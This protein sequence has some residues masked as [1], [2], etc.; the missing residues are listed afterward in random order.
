MSITCEI[1][2]Q[3]GATPEQ[4]RAVGVALWHWCIRTEGD[5]SIYQYL[6]NQPLADLIAGKL[7][8]SSPTPGPA[9]GRGVHFCVRDEASYDRGT[10]IDSLRHDIPAQGV[11]DILVGGKSWNRFD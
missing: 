4:V 6:D 9:E 10:T 7:P 3:W 11:E 5:A 2:L 1:I 8:A